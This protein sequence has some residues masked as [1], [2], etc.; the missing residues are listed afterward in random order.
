M[1]ELVT[2]C[3]PRARGG[4]G[5]HSGQAEGRPSLP[6]PRPAHLCGPLASPGSTNLSRGW[7]LWGP[8]CAFQDQHLGL[9]VPGDQL[10]PA[11]E[12]SLGKGS[13]LGE[14]GGTF[15]P[16]GSFSGDGEPSGELGLFCTHNRVP[17]PGLAFSW[18]EN[19]LEESTAQMI[20]TPSVLE[21]N[22]GSETY[23]YRVYRNFFTEFY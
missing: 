7:A 6:C 23:K 2:D 16:S 14:A 20:Q 9:Q 1:W 8:C 18:D 21:K 4:A 15:W 13:E 3:L 11:D 22:S 10:Q 17:R 5:A 19:V 12:R